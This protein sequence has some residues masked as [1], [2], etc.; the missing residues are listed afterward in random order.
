MT[1]TSAGYRGA[2]QGFMML[3]PTVKYALAMMVRHALLR[4]PYTLRWLFRG[5]STPVSLHSQRCSCAILWVTF[6][7][8]L[9]KYCHR[10]CRCCI[11]DGFSREPQP[12]ELLPRIPPFGEGLQV[13]S[14]K[15]FAEASCSVASATAWSSA[16]IEAMNAAISSLSVAIASVTSAMAASSSWMVFSRLFFWLCT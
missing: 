6:H 10:S 2:Q 15:P 16:A 1:V 3:F 4:C 5:A 13:G 12:F 8:G 11:C 9:M 14:A 7:T